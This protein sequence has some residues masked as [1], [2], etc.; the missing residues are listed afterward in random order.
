MWER[1]SL[2]SEN[3]NWAGSPRNPVLQPTARVSSCLCDKT[4]A[5]G[6]VPNTLISPMKSQSWKFTVTRTWEAMIAVG[7]IALTQWTA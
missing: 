1:L 7:F 2:E 4:R 6:Y 3:R 5:D